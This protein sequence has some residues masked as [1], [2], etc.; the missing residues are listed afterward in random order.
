MTKVFILEKD[1]DIVLPYKTFDR[2]FID[3]RKK[4]KRGKRR[5][6]SWFVYSAS[7]TDGK[8]RMEIKA[9]FD[10][11][12]Y[13]VRIDGWK[14]GEHEDA[15][16]QLKRFH[17]ADDQLIPLLDYVEDFFELLEAWA[18][19]HRGSLYLKYM[20]FKEGSGHIVKI[21]KGL[22][23]EQFFDLLE[24]QELLHDYGYSKRS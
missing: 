4:H 20:D 6:Q 23:K 8:F 5:D 15:S 19:D 24:E 21:I 9:D 14:V 17:F 1:I 13:L 18:V 11:E 2:N 12:D 22:Q 7:P 16:I 10:D 3:F